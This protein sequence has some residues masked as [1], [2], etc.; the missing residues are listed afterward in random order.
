MIGLI[1]LFFIL[2]GG[3]YIQ[4]GNWYAFINGHV[5]IIVGCYLGF[6]LIL[7]IYHSVKG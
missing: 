7:D 1:S 4:Q 5:F 6:N 2:L 3:S